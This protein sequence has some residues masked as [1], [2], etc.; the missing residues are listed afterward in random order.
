MHNG[1][2]S[3]YR[4][5]AE[6]ST[7]LYPGLVV[8]DGRVTGS[9]TIGASRLPL[10]SAAGYFSDAFDVFAHDYGGVDEAGEVCVYG[11]NGNDAYTFFHNLLEQ[12]GEFARLLLVLADVERAESE[13]G[14]FPMAP[15]WWERSNE[16][17]RVR[18]QLQRCIEALAA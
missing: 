14:D 9:I 16:C 10:R 5:P 15:P 4:E 13:E 3:I 11:F 8:H 12:R 7:D 18:A 17:A 6:E 2:M 1:G